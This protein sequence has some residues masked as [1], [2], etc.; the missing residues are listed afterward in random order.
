[1]IEQAAIE[2]IEQKTKDLIR[3]FKSTNGDWEESS[4][5]LLSR[6]FGAR[7]NAD[8]FER[9][10]RSIPIKILLKHLND[11]FQI[12]ALL[13]GQSGL[14]PSK[15]E[16][17]MVQKWSKEYQFLKI[18][19][20]LTPL[21]LDIWKFARM[22][23]ISFP[24]IRIS[25]LAHLITKEEK[26]FSFLLGYTS[27]DELIQLLTL[28]T[29]LFWETHFHFNKQ[30]DPQKKK[31]GKDARNTILIN[32]IVPI[33][34]FYGEK[35]VL[36]QYK[37]KAISLL[38]SLKP[39]NNKITRLWKENDILSNDALQSQGLIQLK[40]TYCDHNRCLQCKIGNHILNNS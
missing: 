22:R 19:Y 21:P 26:L 37:D 18:K 31:L 38:E 30:S 29:S 25:Q 1:M 23:P 15:H 32:A 9:L 28:E 7:V 20:S 6:Y 4:Y 8:A 5:I 17:K 12:E 13:L 14:L 11:P 39:E 16:D 36:A 40:K 2:R 27:N 10:A 35:M 24:T 33:L 34:Y 3:I